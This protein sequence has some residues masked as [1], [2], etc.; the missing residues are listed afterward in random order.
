MAEAYLVPAVGCRPPLGTSV[1]LGVHGTGPLPEAM[2]CM[3]EKE[4]HFQALRRRWEPAACGFPRAAWL[5]FP[6]PREGAEVKPFGVFKWLLLRKGWWASAFGDPGA[7]PPLTFK[8]EGLPIVLLLASTATQSHRAPM[9]PRR[10]SGQEPPRP[11]ESYPSSLASR[12]EAQADM[13]V[14]DPIGSELTFQSG[15]SQLWN[16]ATGGEPVIMACYLGG[17]PLEGTESIAPPSTHTLLLLTLLSPP[18]TGLSL[19]ARQPH[20]PPRGW[21]APFAKSGSP[22]NGLP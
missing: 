15:F 10:A 9:P 21:R 3:C 12:W 4:T 18:T 20:Q 5:P 16:G 19:L 2:M 8:N 11:G 6:E 14:R 17:G 22:P 13:K 1:F 7:L